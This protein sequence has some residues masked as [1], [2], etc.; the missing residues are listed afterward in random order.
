METTI[1]FIK[2]V[3]GSRKDEAL[4]IIGSKKRLGAA[5]VRARLPRGIAGT[6]R[7]IV[8]IAVGTAF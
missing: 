4:V 2:T 6:W 1:R 8:G 7:A 3:R 5:D